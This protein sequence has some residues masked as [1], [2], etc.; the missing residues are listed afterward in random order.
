MAAA[1]EAGLTPQ[2]HRADVPAQVEISDFRVYTAAEIDSA[3]LLTCEGHDPFIGSV[4]LDPESPAAGLRLKRDQWFKRCKKRQFGSMVNLYHLLAVRGAAKQAMELA[5]LRGLKLMMM[6][7]D[8]ATGEWPEEIEPLH[9]IWSEWVLP[10]VNNELFNNQHEVFR[11]SERDFTNL[12]SGCFLLDGHKISPALR[13][14]AFDTSSFDVA[15][16]RERFGGTQQCY[17]QI[18]YSQRARRVL[19]QLD[20]KLIFRPVEIR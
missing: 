2:K 15:V 12:Q 3:P 19:E 5:E 20:S 11:S 16:T 7:T 9:L 1:I 18:V 4:V 14:R 10:E 8:S 13:Y 17:S 6:P